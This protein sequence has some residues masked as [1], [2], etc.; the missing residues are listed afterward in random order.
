MSFP[1]SDNLI[2]NR[3]LSKAKELGFHDESDC[4][5][6]YIYYPNYPLI[7]I[8]LEED[9]ESEQKLIIE[10]YKEWLIAKQNQFNKDYH[11]KI[12][13]DKKEYNDKISELFVRYKRYICSDECRYAETSV[14]IF[15]YLILLVEDYLKITQKEATQDEIDMVIKKII[16][17]G[18]IHRH[19]ARFIDIEEDD[20]TASSIYKKQCIAYWLTKRGCCVEFISK[21]HEMYDS[22]RTVYDS[23]LP[24]CTK[25]D[26]NEMVLE[27]YC[28]NTS[29]IRKYTQGNI[30]NKHSLQEII[31]F[32]GDGFMYDIPQQLVE[33]AISNNP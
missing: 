4:Y 2:A 7:K 8:E 15:D 11:W 30:P 9:L 24:F 33:M 20:D 26:T 3:L 13:T 18:G 21:H 5:T 17:R 12:G 31:D 16:E 29:F 23:L 19:R 10:G 22:L 32:I 27:K 6:D 14:V 1:K 25:D 28:I